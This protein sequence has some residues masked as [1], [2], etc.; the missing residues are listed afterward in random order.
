[1]I[2]V[3]ETS[4]FRAAST[5]IRDFIESRKTGEPIP[6]ESVKGLLNAW[7][8]KSGMILIAFGTLTTSVVAISQLVLLYRQENILNNQSKLMNDQ[9]QL[10]MYGYVKEIKN[11]LAKKPFNE[12]GKVIDFYENN[13]DEISY[14]LIASD[15]EIENVVLLSKLDNNGVVET[16]LKRRFANKF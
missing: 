9:N 11:L 16:I 6:F 10:E 5:F 3:R 8:F 12:K 14:W 1:M 4:R 2:K 13:R 7:L 15:S